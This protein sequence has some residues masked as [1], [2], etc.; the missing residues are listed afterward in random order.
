MGYRS[1][2]VFIVAKEVMPQ[3]LATMAKSPEARK[4]CFSETDKRI[5]DFQGDGNILFNWSYIKWYEGYEEIDAITD[6]MDW[7]DSQDPA[8]EQNATNFY[9]FVRV[10]EETDDNVIRGYGFEDVYI[11]RS[12]TF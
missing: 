8:D 4:M 2:V 10:G 5:K 1:E 7:C 9:R 6:F 11:E 12:I 3:F